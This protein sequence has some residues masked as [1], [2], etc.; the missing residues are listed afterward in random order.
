MSAGTWCSALPSLFH[1]Q[2]CLSY[3]ERSRLSGS[4]IVLLLALCTLML[5]VALLKYVSWVAMPASF[6]DACTNLE[7]RSQ[8]LPH[9]LFLCGGKIFFFEISVEKG[10][11]VFFCL[12]V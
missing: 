12:F 2:H 6:Y 7:H 3:S 1:V 8:M 5:L 4:I 9:S 10:L 11:N